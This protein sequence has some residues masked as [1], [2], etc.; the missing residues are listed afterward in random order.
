[1]IATGD[2][3]V[4]AISGW[5][6]GGMPRPDQNCIWYQW[7]HDKPAGRTWLHCNDINGKV[8]WEACLGLQY[9]DNTPTP[10]WPALNGETPFTV[11]LVVIELAGIANRGQRDDPTHSLVVRHARADHGC[12]L[13]L[14]IPRAC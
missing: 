14:A 9:E 11:K 7:R 2:M 12:A 5:A 3:L 4:K 8:T 10:W 13:M 6:V 1:M